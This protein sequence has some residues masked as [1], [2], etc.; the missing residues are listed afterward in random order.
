MSRRG[1]SVASAPR[2]RRGMKMA[3]RFRRR[4]QGANATRPASRTGTTIIEIVMAVTILGVALPPLIAAYAEASRQTVFPAQATVA[5][6]LLTER[7]EEIVARR[8]RGASGTQASYNAIAAANFPD[9]VPI[10]GFPMYERRVTVTE[11]DRSLNP[12]GSPVG[13]KKVRVVVRWNSGADQMFLERVF[14][15]F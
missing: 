4:P 10:A 13:Y 1:T 15:E 3:F 12:V 7:M 6:F 8:Y 11:V 9:E 2:G 5:S 14:A